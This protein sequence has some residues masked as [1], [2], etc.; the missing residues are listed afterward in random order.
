MKEWKPKS[1]QKLH[2]ANGN[3]A[4]TASSIPPA[5]ADISTS[6]NQVEVAALSE[7]IAQA[8]FLQDEHVIIPKHLQVPES[9]RSHL[10]FGSFE[11]G[12]DSIMAY[13][14]DISEVRVPEKLTDQS[15]VR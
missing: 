6:L 5:C 2:T 15:F 10:I 11:A 3:V 8:K 13:A 7:K 4:K 14:S 12:F 1:N 9:E